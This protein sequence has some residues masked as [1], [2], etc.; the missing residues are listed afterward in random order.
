MRK[1]K[2]TDLKATVKA[3]VLRVY[4]YRW[5]IDNPNR[6]YAW[7]GMKHKPTMPLVT[8]EEWLESVFFAVTK[9]GELDKRYR[10]IVF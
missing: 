7:R 1:T 3:Q 2:G 9:T 6:E 10:S 5:T 8:D 4:I